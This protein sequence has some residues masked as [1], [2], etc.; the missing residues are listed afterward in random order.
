M[1]IFYINGHL[2]DVRYPVDHS[3]QIERRGI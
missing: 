2:F 1:D 3:M